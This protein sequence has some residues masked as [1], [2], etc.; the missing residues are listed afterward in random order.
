MTDPLGQEGGHC[1][2]GSQSTCFPAIYSLSDLSLHCKQA[3]G[4][5]CAL[6]G[7]FALLLHVII[8]SA[9]LSISSICLYP[10]AFFFIF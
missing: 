5:V 8:S 2:A 3:T 6:W 9:T 4:I 10:P 1:R 7:S